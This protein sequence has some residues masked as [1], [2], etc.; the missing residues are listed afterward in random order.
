MYVDPRIHQKVDIVIADVP[1][2]YGMWLS[3]DWSEKL[4]GYFSTY[5]SHLWLPYN[6]MPNHIKINREPLMKQTVMDLND[7]VEPAVFVNS[8]IEHYT[9]D[10]YFGDMA[11]DT[12]LNHNIDKLS[13]IIIVNLFH[14]LVKLYIMYIILIPML[15][16][17]YHHGHSFLMDLSPNMV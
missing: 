4:E 16:Y 5:W 1:K 10:S 9:L 8:V 17:I 3:R 2:K 7:L 6:G 11:I 13:K 15:Y 12:S 14:L